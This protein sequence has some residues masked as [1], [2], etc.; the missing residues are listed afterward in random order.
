MANVCNACKINLTPEAETISHMF[1]ILS[2]ALTF[3]LT[4][5]ISPSAIPKAIKDISITE[6]LIIGQ[7]SWGTKLS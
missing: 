4:T 3:Y 5:L 7:F 2:L 1:F 6:D